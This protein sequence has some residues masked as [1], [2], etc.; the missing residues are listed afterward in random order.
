[1]AKKPQPVINYVPPAT[2][3]YLYIR[4]WKLINPAPWK[5]DNSKQIEKLKRYLTQR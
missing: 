2:K 3:Y 4:P 1:M 5:T